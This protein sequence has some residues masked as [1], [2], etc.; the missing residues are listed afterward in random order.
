MALR[1]GKPED[2]AASVLA[3]YGNKIVLVR[4]P[5]YTDPKW[6]FPGGKRDTHDSTPRDTAHRELEEETGLRPQ[7]IIELSQFTSH[8]CVGRPNEH[9]CHFF[10]AVVDSLDELSTIGDEG[11]EVEAIELSDLWE[12]DILPSHL[13]IIQAVMKQ[14]RPLQA[15]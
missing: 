11:E 5:D 12:P 7:N 6:K 9:T 14:A 1:F 15:A 3:I 4:D 2:W 10:L 8:R 13:R